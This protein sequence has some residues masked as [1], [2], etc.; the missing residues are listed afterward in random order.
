MAR[1]KTFKSFTFVMATLSVCC[2]LDGGSPLHAQGAYQPGAAYQPGIGG[3]Y[4]PGG[5]P[6]PG[7]AY[8]PGVGGVYQ[9][10]GAPQPGA[11]YPPGSR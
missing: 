4:Q 8:Q 5:A 1:R 7:A 10:G 6:Q 3:A 11:A 2:I 9:P